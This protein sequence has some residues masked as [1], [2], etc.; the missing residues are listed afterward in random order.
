[1]MQYFKDALKMR[2]ELNPVFT[3]AVH[4]DQLHNIDLIQR[5]Y[6]Q[7]R[8]KLKPS[9]PCTT[10]IHYE[11]ASC[12]NVVYPPCVFEESAVSKTV[13]LVFADES[14]TVDDCFRCKLE[15]ARRVDYVRDVTV[16]MIIELLF[17]E[18]ERP[19]RM[20][21]FNVISRRA[22]DVMLS[23]N[24]SLHVHRPIFFE[25]MAFSALTITVHASLTS[26]Q[27]TRKRLSPESIIGSRLRE[28][29]RC[30][31]RAAF[32]TIHS[33]QVFI[34]RH[35]E[36]LSSPINIQ[37]VDVESEIERYMA[38]VEQSDDIWAKLEEVAQSFSSKLTQLF[39]QM[40]QMFSR[41]QRLALALHAE[42]DALR[43][44]RLGEAFICIE[45][46]VNSLITSTSAP[47]H[48][49]SQIAD[50]LKKTPYFSR[51]PKSRFHVDGNDLS[52]AN[53]TVIV[54]RRYLPAGATR[55]ISVECAETP[56]NMEAG[57]SSKRSVSMRL[58]PLFTGLCLPLNCATLEDPYEVIAS[59]NSTTDLLSVPPHRWDVKKC[60]KSPQGS[61]KGC[62][63]M[64]DPGKSLS[65]VA[66]DA[67]SFLR[68]V[69]L[70]RQR[71]KSISDVVELVIPPSGKSSPSSAA[72]LSAVTG[73]AVVF[74]RCL[75]SSHSSVAQRCTPN[76]SP[77]SDRWE[78]ENKSVCMPLDQRLIEFVHLA[79]RCTPNESP[80]SDRWESEN[81]SVC[82]PLD[83]R[84]IEFVHRKESFK[85]KLNSSGLH[86][87]LYS[88]LAYFPGRL[89]YFSVQER[90]LAHNDSHLIVF[91]HG[92]EGGSEDLAPYRNY[93][94]LLLPR[95]NLKFLL[96]ESNQL[97]TWADF[98]QLADNLLNEILAYLESCSI[99]PKRI[100][101][102]AH[103]MGGVIVR[104]MIAK[105][106]ASSI[107]PLLHTLLTLNAPHCGLLYNQRAAN[108][109][110]ALVQWWKQ[111]R[112]LQ[113]LTF[114]DAVAFRDTFLYK[115][116]KNKTFAKFR[117]VLLVGSYH[118]LYVPHHSALIETCKAARKDPS[119]QGSIYE[120]MVNNMHESVA[121]SSRHTTLVKY[122]VIPSMANVPRT[123]QVIGKA[124]HVAVVDDDLF[125]EK[126]LAVSA[127]NYFK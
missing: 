83:Q 19:P 80:S 27:S 36:F 89:P 54:E 119:L 84:L 122:T 43:M 9:I 31:C 75:S 116:S 108:W 120:E 53:M 3:I 32:S 72:E 62:R 125:I 113:Q 25:Y 21:S 97:E 76:E 37:V 6:Y 74:G 11:R 15:V 7:V 60:V 44:K 88:D 40:L 67:A 86:A 71:S 8:F 103:S 29:Y 23:L 12:P 109:G 45:D 30:M 33:L 81:K 77:S 64:T 110:V 50:L 79:Q 1:M 91:V 123:H 107:L 118:D 58:H 87:Y 112:S 28:Y 13:E 59:Q 42:F 106:R 95:S 34:C 41:S 115:L 96:S 73:D 104:C 52:A 4:L 24:Q 47:Q 101:F 70:S 57:D 5:G 63:R 61:L 2:V 14:M 121:S 66:E 85:Q 49:I 39:D 55:R 92:L 68:F 105:Q 51:I 127:A 100:S 20:E 22:V 117:Y 94:R 26:V 102:I 99:P 46:T 93:L 124:A 82:M 56:N 69:T 16:Q 78:T 17:L 38:A 111:S 10:E 35:C 98:N 48:T 18:R 126:L 114:R 90:S 65:I